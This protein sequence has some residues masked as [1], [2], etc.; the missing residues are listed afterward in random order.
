MALLK[1]NKS[2]VVDLFPVQQAN[3]IIIILILAIAVSAPKHVPDR[4]VSLILQW[5]STV[6][7]AYWLPR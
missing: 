4:T 6:S 2:P 3:T 1:W 5:Q 7:I